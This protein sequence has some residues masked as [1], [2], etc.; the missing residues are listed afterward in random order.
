MKYVFYKSEI[1][2]FGD[3]LNAWLWPKIFDTV[4]EIKKDSFFFGIG[5]LLCSKSELVT[6]VEGKNKI[7]FGSGI[8]PAYKPFIPDSSWDI[9]FL[10]G[11]LSALSLSGKY[12][13]IA[14][15]AYASRLISDFKKYETLE[16]K[17]KISVMPY[18]RSVR[19]FNWEN[20]CRNL[21][22]H[23]ISPLSESGV[24]QTFT[25]IASSGLIITESLHGAIIADLL[26]IPWSRF[27]LSTPYTEG[28]MVSEFKWM[29][30]LYSIGL[31]NINTTYIKFYRK[32]VINK[33]IKKITFDAMH[34][35]FL[36][37]KIIRQDILS[38]LS[39]VNE[40][41]LSSDDVIKRIDVRLAEKIYE[42][43]TGI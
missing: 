8:R 2:N 34:V 7:V 13:Y 24:E 19:Y 18:F 33:A 17:Y 12:D 23:Y 27:V 32:S 1:G 3:D 31:P 15:A 9:R 11:P 25:E 14:D 28:S 35:E 4:N 10:R 29:D 20:I 6:P 5:S 22:Y 39:S 26:R 36:V 30:W 38:K 42:L 21:G 37:K 43:K 16:K 40:Y 41:Y